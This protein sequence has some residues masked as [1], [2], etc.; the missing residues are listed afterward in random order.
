[1]KHIM[2]MSACTININAII[3]RKL[4]SN[5]VYNTGKL[6]ALDNVSRYFFANYIKFSLRHASPIYFYILDQFSSMIFHLRHS[7]HVTS[8]SKLLF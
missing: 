8:N 5:L 7:V 4:R 3:T 2:F 1:M 6:L